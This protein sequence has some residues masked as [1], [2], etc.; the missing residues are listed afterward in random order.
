MKSIIKYIVDEQLTLEFERG[1]IKCERVIKL[2]NFNFNK[3]LGVYWS[4]VK[5]MGDSHR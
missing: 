2:N 1:L 3:N 4:Y 5:G